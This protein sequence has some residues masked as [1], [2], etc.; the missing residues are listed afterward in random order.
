[1]IR[2]WAVLAVTLAFVLSP[3]VVEGFGGFKPDQFPIPQEDPPVQPAGYAFAIWS[4]IYLW[5][6]VS[7]GYGVWRA[8]SDARWDA[9]RPGLILSLGVGMFWLKVATLSPI[10]AMV[11][12][13]IMLAGALWALSRAARTGDTWFLMLPVG[14]Y[15]GWLTAASWVSIGLV[16]AGYGIAFGDVAWAWIAGGL[17]ALMA[18]AVAARLRVWTYAFGAGWGLFAVGVQNWGSETALALAAWVATGLIAALTIHQL[19]QG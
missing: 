4:V 9:A 19:R 14:L 5:L 6:L 10:W 3:L 16:G 1:M 17:A 15:T 12:I 8:G 2:A 18:L 7:A 13:W 11:L